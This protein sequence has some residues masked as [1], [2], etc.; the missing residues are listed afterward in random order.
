MAIFLTSILALFAA[1]IQEPKDSPPSRKPNPF[2]PSLPELTDADEAKLDRIIN[3]FIDADSG[4]LP[5][6]DTREAVNDFKGLKPEAIPALIRGL[7]RAAKLDY[8]CPAV[9][10]AAKLARLLRAT[11]DPL[12]LEYARENIG[13][14]I[15]QSRHM[16]VIRDLRLLCLFRKRTL[17]ERGE[18]SFEPFVEPAPPVIIRP[19][20]NDLQKQPTQQLVYAASQET[21]RRLRGVLKELA[22]RDD[23]MALDGLAS[24]AAITEQEYQDYARKLLREKLARLDVKELKRKLRDTLPEIR[25]AAA[26][27]AAEKKVRVEPQ[28]VDMLHDHFPNVREAAHD[29]LVHLA[30]GKDFGPKPNSS[31]DDR[32]KAEAQWR[33]WCKNQT[34]GKQ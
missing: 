14:G 1:G 3:R 25:A 17:A 31:A 11:R 7:N 34:S 18:A 2:A 8:S 20:Q 30:G 13:A 10:I 6:A 28:L 15:T 5:A 19:G 9:T 16:A 4:Q 26:L 23:G 21:G 24:A 29:A 27:T 12:L 32:Q 33:E 22:R